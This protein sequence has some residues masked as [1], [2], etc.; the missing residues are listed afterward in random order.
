MNPTTPVSMLAQMV[1][2]GAKPTLPEAGS[3]L[4]RTAR[5]PGVYPLGD[6]RSEIVGADGKTVGVVSDEQM[7]GDEDTAAEARDFIGNRRA[8]GVYQE[9]SGGVEVVGQDDGPSLFMPEEALYGK[10]DE[11]GDEGVDAATMA[12]MMIRGGG[13]SP[14]RE[15]PQASMASLI[16][17]KDGPVNLASA[18]EPGPAAANQ[19]RAP[20]VY[21]LGGGM[22]EVVGADGVARIISDEQLY[23]GQERTGDTSDQARRA[24][25]LGWEQQMV[26]KPANV[27]NP[28]TLATLIRGIPGRGR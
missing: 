13:G 16:R 18:G 5:A 7:Y 10:G 24:I 21:P 19:R 26:P 27:S 22:S 14:A 12:R 9:R 4:G 3:F 15:Q 25:A 17:G 20:G 6:G 1:R 11:D 2:T 23:G 28:E 8:P